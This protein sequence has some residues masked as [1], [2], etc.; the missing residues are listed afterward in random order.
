M[1]VIPNAVERAV[2][3]LGLLPS[4][5]L[6]VVNAAA[7]RAL[8]VAIR[9]G[10]IERLA[11]G[12]ATLADLAGRC[13]ADER[14]LGALI[15]LLVRTRYLSRRGDLLSLTRAAR[16][17]LVSDGSLPKF[18]EHWHNVLFEHF[19]TLEEAVRAGAPRP[20]LHKWLSSSGRWP[21][22]NAAMA[23]LASSSADA[24]ASAASLPASIRTLVDLGGSHGLNAAAF[25]RRYPGLHATVIDQAEALRDGERR[26]REKGLGDRV[27]FRAG[28]VTSDD[29][30]G[31]YD[32]VLLFQL[33]HYFPP[34][35]N[36]ALLRRVARALAPNGHVLIFDQLRGAAPLPVASAFF[37][38]L[39]LTYRAGLG[40]DLYAFDEIVDWLRSAGFNR[41]RKRTLRAAPGNAL[42]IA[43]GS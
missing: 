21:V 16:R 11:A 7:F 30:G 34:E 38:L 22:F 8:G 41:I 35:T 32:V 14:T 15:E 2:L 23:E 25:C 12:P 3:A 33:V 4:F 17:A 31:P 39:A 27:T 5:L 1:P 26:I 20:H 42:I 36:Q 10:V 18:A 28:D 43:R 29:L 13:G 40:G 9:L 6:D 24:I 19:D 37:A